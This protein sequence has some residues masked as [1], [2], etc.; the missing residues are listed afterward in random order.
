MA[1]EIIML[2]ATGPMQEYLLRVQV[3]LHSMEQE[4]KVLEQQLLVMLHSLVEILK[5]PQE[6]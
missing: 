1:Q 6:I 4:H 5:L 2:A 3:P